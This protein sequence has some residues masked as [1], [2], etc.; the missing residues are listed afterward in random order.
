MPDSVLTPGQAVP[1]CSDTPPPPPRPSLFCSSPCLCHSQGWLGW[2]SHG[3]RA[4][5]DSSPCGQVGD[6]LQGKGQNEGWNLEVMRKKSGGGP[7]KRGL[8]WVKQDLEGFGGWGNDK[9]LE[10]P[11]TGSWALE[12]GDCEL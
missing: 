12:D 11:G 3:S 2:G 4:D 7:Q 6:L 1:S 8:G 5:L 10:D 9:S